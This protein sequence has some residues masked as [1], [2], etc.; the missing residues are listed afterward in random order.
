SLLHLR[1]KRLNTLLLLR[2]GFCSC[3]GDLPRSGQCGSGDLWRS[4]LR[5]ACMLRGGAP[6]QQKGQ[7]GATNKS[8]LNSAHVQY[9]KE[10]R[11]PAAIGQPRFESGPLADDK[12]CD[13]GPLRRTRKNSAFPP[14]ACHSWN[15][16]SYAISRSLPISTMESRH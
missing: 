5:A 6:F 11:P 16:V 15:H 8:I 12:L 13:G 7:S 9:Q 1:N 4:V 14:L 2:G 10:L 3:C